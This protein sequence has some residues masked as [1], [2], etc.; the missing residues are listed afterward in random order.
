MTLKGVIKVG[1]P[2]NF[3]GS[4]ADRKDMLDRYYG[5]DENIQTKSPCGLLKAVGESKKSREELGIPKLLVMNSE[6]DPVDEILKSNDD[7]VKLGEEV[8]G[9]KI[10]VIKIQG[11]NHISPPTALSSGEGEEWGEQVARWIRGN[12]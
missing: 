10:E 5:S 2:Y 4:R 3:D 8:W 6:W 11:H 9:E 7:F 12:A 1:A